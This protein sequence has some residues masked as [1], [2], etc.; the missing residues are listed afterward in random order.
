MKM[1]D[2]KAIGDISEHT[3]LADKYV[4]VDNS[5][6]FFKDDCQIPV[7]V[8]FNPQYVKDVTK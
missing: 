6:R 2:V 3:V 8:V 1:F 7:F 5:V 4:I